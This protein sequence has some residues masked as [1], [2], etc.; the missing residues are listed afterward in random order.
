[1]LDPPAAGSPREPLQGET[2]DSE[3]LG[4]S[5]VRRLL[6]IE[7]QKKQMMGGALF[8]F[9]KDVK[10]Y[11]CPRA[12]ANE[13]RSFSVVDGM[14]VIVI[15]AA[16]L[17]T[18]VKLLK[19]RQEI[20]KAYERMIFVD[21]GGSQGSTHGRLDGLFPKQPVSMVGP[22]LGTTRRRNN[23]FFRGWP[24][25]IPQMAGIQHPQMRQ[26]FNSCQLQHT[27][28]AKEGHSLGTDCRM[29]YRA[30]SKVVSVVRGWAISGIAF[31]FSIAGL[32]NFTRRKNYRLCTI[33]SAG[34]Q[35]VAFGD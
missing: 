17:N 8:R 26:R 23:F 30:N 6:P 9:V 19:T 33:T 15:G 4:D 28:H 2:L 10:A 22:A 20:K 34:V 21:D 3:G 32:Q 7:E 29:G 18:P 14:N 16:V 35:A 1:M 5:H 24:Q 12:H 27:T 31:L 13:G 11:K 25:R